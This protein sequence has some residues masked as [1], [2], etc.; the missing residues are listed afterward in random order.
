MKTKTIS[1]PKDVFE[2]TFLSKSNYAQQGEWYQNNPPMSSTDYGQTLPQLPTT[3]NVP[4]QGE[5]F[6]SGSYNKSQY[7]SPTNTEG[8]A[9]G[10]EYDASGKVVKKQNTQNSV[11][12]MNPFGG[13]SMDYALNFAGEGFGSGN[14][15]QAAVGT[16]TAL[17]KGTRNFLSGYSTGKENKRVGQ[18]YDDKRFDK[19][20]NYTYSFQQGGVKNSDIIAQ[21]AITDQGQGNVNLEGSEFVMRTN[22]QVQP[23]VGDKHIENGKKA[24][25][26]NAQLEDGDK[27]L[28]NYVKLKPN[29][30]KELKDRYDISLKKGVTFADA[31]KKL[32]QK[33]GIKKLETEKADILEKIEKAT[34]IKD[35][36]T[37]QLSLEVLTK[38][39]GDV[40]EKLN[41]LSGVRADN[42]E[43]LFQRQEM[44]PKKGKQ[45][46]LFHEN[47]KIVEG[48]ESDIFQ[49]G[50]LIELKDNEKEYLKAVMKGRR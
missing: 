40:N 46:E 4:N 11:N 6:G 15:G 24:D 49:Q 28:S 42:F 43:F 13:I 17:L 26:V 23:V 30:I 45:G 38:K 39:T 19:T 18:E 5:T 16:G 2:K 14:Y 12:I 48:T 50:G 36:D 37:K 9:E 8:L 22:G 35:S 27:V 44:I 34:K 47:G 32:D 31:Q 1:I 33:L 20:P 3:Q 41:T 25:G 10:Y 21:N 7:S 29:D